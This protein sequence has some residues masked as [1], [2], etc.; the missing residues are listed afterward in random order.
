MLES[1]YESSK[2]MEK[3]ETKKTLRE[4]CLGGFKLI[5]YTQNTTVSQQR[6]SKIFLMFL[7]DDHKVRD[8]SFIEGQSLGV[9]WS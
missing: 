5:Y 2:A 4:K 1:G 3:K 9:H 8:S 6:E 7:V